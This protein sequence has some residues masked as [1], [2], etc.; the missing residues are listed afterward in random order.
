MREGRCVRSKSVT[1]ARRIGDGTEAFVS[2]IDVIEGGEQ[3]FVFRP[4]GDMGRFVR[5]R[6]GFSGPPMRLRFGV[7]V[8]ADEGRFRR[9]VGEGFAGAE[10]VQSLA[11]DKAASFRAFRRPDLCEGIVKGRRDEVRVFCKDR[12]VERINEAVMRLEGGGSR[13]RRERD[14]RSLRLEMILFLR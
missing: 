10:R 2:E 3:F 11:A 4:E 12:I 6:L 9:A 7:R 1:V 8:R 5:R 14:R 13:F